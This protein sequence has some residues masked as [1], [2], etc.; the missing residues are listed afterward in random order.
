MK[1]EDH[2]IYKE[3]PQLFRRARKEP[4]LAWQLYAE[5][6]ERG[7][8][9]PEIVLRFDTVAKR[10]SELIMK[11]PKGGKKTAAY[12]NAI[13]DALQL[14]ATSGRDSPFVGA[15]RM[16]EV[17]AVKLQL[18]R[19]EEQ[20]GRLP[21]KGD[22]LT[23]LD[24]MVARTLHVTE[25]TAQKRREKAQAELHCP[26]S[27]SAT[28]SCSIKRSRTPGRG[29]RARSSLAPIEPRLDHL[30]CAQHAPCRGSS[31]NGPVAARLG[32]SCRR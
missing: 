5:C 21:T 19:F 14:T 1:D 17:H 30:E 23:G 3:D 7:L 9:I 12:K 28:C 32:F 27:G 2:P 31:Q 24:K 6:R 25:S 16:R 11:P 4:M 8:P 20:H 18:L 29:F 22:D 10:F 26:T 15:R 13:V